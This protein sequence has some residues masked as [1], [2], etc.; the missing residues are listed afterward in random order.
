MQRLELIISV[1]CG[2]IDK[3]RDNNNLYPYGAKTLSYPNKTTIEQYPGRY[4]ISF[5]ASVFMGMSD[6]DIIWEMT[7]ALV[8]ILN[9]Y[10]NF[11]KSNL[12]IKLIAT[13]I[14]KPTGENI[15][16]A[17]QNKINRINDIMAKINKPSSI[18]IP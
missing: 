10:P 1:L 18:L 6:D 12:Y 15:D 8:N 17:I 2:N 5:E 3:W 11:S 4:V 9:K 13:D 16:R 7:G 14:E